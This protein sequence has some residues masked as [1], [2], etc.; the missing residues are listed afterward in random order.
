MGKPIRLGNSAFD[1]DA[2]VETDCGECFIRV[3]A[4]EDSADPFVVVS[5]VSNHDTLFRSR[6]RERLRRAWQIIRYRYSDTWFEFGDK[7]HVDTFIK[8]LKRA[9]QAAWPK[10]EP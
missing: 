3:Q 8:A 6:F 1:Y 4:W 9:S 10:E 7:R 5:V 2:L